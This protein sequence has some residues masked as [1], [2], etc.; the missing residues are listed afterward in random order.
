MSVEERLDLGALS[1]CPVVAVMFCAW[2]AERK[3]GAVGIKGV[4]EIAEPNDGS[5]DDGD[6]NGLR[7]VAVVLFDLVET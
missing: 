4:A 1:A 3:F 6:D 5:A 2:L 7:L